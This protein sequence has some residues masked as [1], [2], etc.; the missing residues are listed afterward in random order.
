MNVLVK[1]V[2]F[3]VLENKLQR[4]WARGGKISIIDM[5][6]DYFLVNFSS[7]EDYKNCSLQWAFACCGSLLAYS[8]METLRHGECG[9][10]QE[11]GS[12]D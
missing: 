3:K 6:Q 9:D 8:K 10:Y 4:S 7:L 1:K 2:G 12:L 11:G 5:P